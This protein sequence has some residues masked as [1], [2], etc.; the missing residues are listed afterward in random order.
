MEACKTDIVGNDA[1][2]VAS[3]EVLRELEHMRRELKQL[4]RKAHPTSRHSGQAE[5][6]SYTFLWRKIDK[7]LESFLEVEAIK[8]SENLKPG[9]KIENSSTSQ[10]LDDEL[11]NLDDL[12][13]IERKLKKDDNFHFKV[14][15]LHVGIIGESLQKQVNSVLRMVLDDKLA[16]LFNWKGQRGNKLKLSKR[17]ISRVI[18][19]AIAKEIPTINDTIFDRKAGPWLAQASFRLKNIKTG[20]KMT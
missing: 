11:K 10:V 6:S 14:D 7:N 9:Q 2:R 5:M 3:D 13:K 8:K 15:A 19:K 16:N 17:R 20:I 4:R 1:P 12:K 18:I